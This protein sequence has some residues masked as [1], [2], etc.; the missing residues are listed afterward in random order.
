MFKIYSNIGGFLYE[1]SP[2]LVVG[3]CPEILP[4]LRRLARD[5]LTSLIKPPQKKVVID[6]LYLSLANQVNVFLVLAVE[7]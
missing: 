5:S 2:I 1:T 3:H 4:F 7:I 6:Y